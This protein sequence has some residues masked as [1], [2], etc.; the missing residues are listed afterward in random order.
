MDLCSVKPQPNLYHKDWPTYTLWHNDP[1]APTGIVE[2][3]HGH[4]WD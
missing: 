2:V 1:P 3:D 4:K